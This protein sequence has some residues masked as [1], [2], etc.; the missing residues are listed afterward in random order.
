MAVSRTDQTQNDATV[1]AVAPSI[2]A[3]VLA[4]APGHVPSR[5]PLDLDL[6]DPRSFDGLAGP[7]FD[8]VLRESETAVADLVAIA[9]TSPQIF[10]NHLFGVKEASV[11][12]QM[13]RGLSRKRGLTKMVATSILTAEAAQG[14]RETYIVKPWVLMSAVQ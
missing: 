12:M 4:S 11:A 13:L 10:T 5:I 1:H 8:G 6:T 7:E 14:G 9:L 3:G 2:R